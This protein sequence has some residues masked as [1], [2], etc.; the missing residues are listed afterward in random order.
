MVDTESGEG[1]GILVVEDDEQLQT[2]LTKVLSQNGY[3]VT[4]AR[5]GYEGLERMERDAPWL[6]LTDLNL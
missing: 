5:D 1:R 3:A 6:V 2:A 4:V